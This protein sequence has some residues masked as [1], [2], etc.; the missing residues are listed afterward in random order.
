M[1]HSGSPVAS[2]HIESRIL[3]FFSS[4]WMEQAV[5]HIL[6]RAGLRVHQ[7]R[8]VPPALARAVDIVV[9]DA[10]ALA[11]HIV[12]RIAPRAAIVL[13]G[14]AASP[15]HGYPNHTRHLGPSDGVSSLLEGLRE[16]ATSTPRS[17]AS[18][19]TPRQRE[20]LSLVS[21][22]A[23]NAEIAEHLMI[24]VGTVKRHLHDIYVALGV[25]TRSEAA[26]VSL[27]DERN[28]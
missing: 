19:L 28:L 2:P 22:G 6:E 23:R 18:S 12:Q 14:E 9:G 16:V 8:D 7:S 1:G 15:R 10:G 13:H 3:L 25:R 20:V 21:R 11:P 17:A 4:A 26:F 5:T 24:S 27:T